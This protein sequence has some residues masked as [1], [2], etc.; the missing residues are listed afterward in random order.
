MY[1]SYI[2]DEYNKNAY[3]ELSII[4]SQGIHSKY[5]H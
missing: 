5:L 1:V 4:L 2:P 3:L